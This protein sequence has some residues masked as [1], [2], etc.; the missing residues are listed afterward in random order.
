MGF[1][2]TVLLDRDGTINVERNYL[3]DPDGVEL[4]PNAATGLRIM[5]GRGARLV[6][7]TNQSAIGRG[8]FDEA[9]LDAIHDRLRA[10]LAA[11]GVD[12]DTK[13]YV[14]PHRPDDG[15][16]C[17]KPAGGLVEQAVADLDF[18]PAEAFVIGDKAS[19][20]AL[21]QRFGATTILV[22]S[23]Y[24]RSEEENRSVWPDFV[25]DDLVEAAELVDQ[26]AGAGWRIRRHVL[27]D[28][29]TKQRLLEECE[30]SILAAA[31][32]VAGAL[33]AGGKLLIC[34]NGGSAADAQHLAA[35]FVSLLDTG[36][37]RPGLAA[38]AL[39]TDTSFLTAYS[40]DFEYAGIFERQ[41]QALGRPGDVVLGISTSGNSKNVVRAL[42]Y[43][44]EHGMK[45]V[46]LTGGR[47]GAMVDVADV[48]VRVPS[49]KVQRVQESHLAIE[50]L[51]TE[52]VERA[53]F[54][55]TGQSM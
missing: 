48:A 15:C 2:P 8:Y 28:M 44:Q 21:G 4:L 40:N 50:H 20:I 18:D 17:R 23:G 30:D 38:I 52:L 14:C 45:T 27:A 5:Q 29:A 34:G 22:R 31:D 54:G 51:I 49:T 25:V 33:R 46:A 32:S 24:G 1:V 12:L 41:V 13:I 3:S 35:E 6:V 55:A 37:P 10:L 9:R 43:A 42:Q 36:F 19:D 11:E 39:T 16:T 26:I 7:L 53:L 47:G